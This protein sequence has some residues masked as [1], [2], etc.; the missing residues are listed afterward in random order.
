MFKK[1]PLNTNYSFDIGGNVMVDGVV[2][3]PEHNCEF[4]NIPTESVTQIF[5]KEWLSL[6]CHY[7]VDLPTEKLLQITFVKC[8]S[9]VIKLRC[10]RLMIFK[11]KIHFDENF[12]HIPGFT[13]F[14]IN[15]EGVVVGVKSGRILNQAIGP[16]GYPYVNIYDPDKNKWRSVSVH[17]LIARVFV[18]NDD[19]ESRPY[20]NHKDGNK[21]NYDYRNLEWVSSRENQ[22]HAISNNLRN[23][24][25]SC[26]I[27]DITTGNINTYPSL[28]TGFE[29]CGLNKSS[30]YLQVKNNGVV[31][32]KLIKGRYEVKL[33]DDESEW[34]H[35]NNPGVTIDKITGVIEAKNIGTNTVVEAMSIP[36]MAKLINVDPTTVTDAIRS[37]IN[38]VKCGYL[39]R[40]KTDE[41]W[42]DDY[43][44]S[45]FVEPTRLLFK[46][47]ITGEEIYFPSKRKACE[48]FGVDKRTLSSRIRNKTKLGEWE[49]IPL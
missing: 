22:Q 4:L 34:Y 46:N 19:Y 27:M 41:P 29:A 26:K 16:Y 12:Y 35:I 30:L 1:L 7:E 38:Q 14:A 5:S 37:P 10:K 42:S 2:N 45:N 18:K 9:K 40:I 47:S 32:P 21:L 31:I 43:C 6:I 11:K 49:V 13:R 25:V 24:N 36:A 48:Y 15:S 17:I 3:S 28:K 44:L 8:T 39:F 23:D 33:I 20:V